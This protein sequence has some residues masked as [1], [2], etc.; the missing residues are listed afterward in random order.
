MN[1]ARCRILSKQYIHIHNSS[2][3]YE[4]FM[5][6]IQLSMTDEYDINLA[7]IDKK[8]YK[9]FPTSYSYLRAFLPLFLVVF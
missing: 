6:D 3:F 1:F 2:L 4:D 7:R 5:L 9:I 8:S